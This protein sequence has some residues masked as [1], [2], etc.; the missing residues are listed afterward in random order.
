MNRGKVA[1]KNHMAFRHSTDH[2]HVL[3][4][5]CDHLPALRVSPGYVV[6]HSHCS[7]QTTEKIKTLTALSFTS[8][9]GQT[10]VA[11]QRKE[12][13]HQFTTEQSL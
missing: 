6:S 9:A 1:G 7:D 4:V 10:K 3:G 13:S 12:L 2:I 11:V 5:L 8:G